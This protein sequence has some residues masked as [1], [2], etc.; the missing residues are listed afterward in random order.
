MMNFI[1]TT[2]AAFATSIITTFWD[3]Q[4]ARHHA[5]LAANVTSYDPDTSGFLGGLSALGLDPQQSATLVNQMIDAQAATMAL[6]DYFA[7]ASLV[8][9]A[10]I[11]FIWLARPVKITSLGVPTH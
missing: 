6:N 10:L 5:D 2:A 11:G 4:E 1:R 9:V 7:F 3:S 8:L